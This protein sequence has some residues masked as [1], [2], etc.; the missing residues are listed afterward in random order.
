MLGQGTN[1][2]QRGPPRAWRFGSGT[3]ATDGQ[4]AVNGK[5]ASAGPESCF[6]WPSS[7]QYQSFPAAIP[8]TA[9]L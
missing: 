9:A 8:P 7:N 3:L 6:P 4:L 5:R 1:H 2:Q